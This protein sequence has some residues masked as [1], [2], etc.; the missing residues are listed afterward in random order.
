SNGVNISGSSTGTFQ[1]GTGVQINSAT[2][3]AFNVSGGTPV[4]EYDG[5]IT[6]GNAANAVAITGVTGGSTAGVASPY[7]IHFNGNITKNGTAATAI[8]ITS[9]TGGSFGFTGTTMSLAGGGNIAVNLAPNAGA[10]I[11]FGAGLAIT[12]SS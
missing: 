3:A 12:T 7:S 1:F 5:P 2:G 10:S 6:Q 11:T 9:N 8:S 4:I